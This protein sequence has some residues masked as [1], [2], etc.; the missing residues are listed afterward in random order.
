MVSGESEMCCLSRVSLRQVVIA[1]SARDALGRVVAASPARDWHRTSCDSISCT[2]LASGESW[3]RLPFRLDIRRV[4]VTMDSKSYTIRFKDQIELGSIPIFIQFWTKIY[5]VPYHFVTHTGES[6]LLLPLELGLGRVVTVSPAWGGLGW[7]LTAYPTRGW[8]EA[9]RDNISHLGLASSE[10][11][12]SLPPE[13]DLEQ[14]VTAS[15]A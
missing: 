4:G 1:S 15:P 11:W 8:P 7:V 3:M 12:L 2:R 9:S 10:S 5:L 14:V 13:I 6:W